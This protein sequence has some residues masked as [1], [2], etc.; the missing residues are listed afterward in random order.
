MRVSYRRES[1]PGAATKSYAILADGEPAG[2]AH[3]I[4]RRWWIA[5][6]AEGDG[7]C[8]AETRKAAVALL[9]TRRFERLEG[10]GKIFGFLA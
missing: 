4:A 9:L 2:N 7:A 3:R 8:R 1:A 6:N 5:S 10:P